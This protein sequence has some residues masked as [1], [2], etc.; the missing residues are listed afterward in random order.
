VTAWCCA[1]H[2]L[3]DVER[4]T[5]LRFE[6]APARLDT[7]SAQFVLKLRGGEGTRIV[8]Q[9]GCGSLRKE[10]WKIREYYLRLARHV[11]RHAS[12]RAATLDGSNAV[13]NELARWSV[14][15]LYTLVTDTP[16]WPYPY[17]GIPLFSTVFG[18]DGIITALLTLWAD[19]TIAKGVIGFLAAEQA[20][21]VKP[22]SDA[23][24]GKILHE[25]REGELGAARRG[26][27]RPLLRQRRR[28]AALCH[29]GGRVFRADRQSRHD[30]CLVAQHH[31]GIAADR[32]LRRSRRRRVC[33]I[34][35]AKRNR[36]EQ[37][38]LEGVDV[39]NE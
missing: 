4:D 26:A 21:S 2:G 18:R 25:M 29:A 19:P 6:P 1:T 33:R 10:G 13:F 20:T 17:A 3:D 34:P 35:A 30:P 8:L 22:E 27:V 37:P 9:A 12:G 28:D 38:G 36:V 14:A 32:H 23:A 39:V 7:S 24:P 5:N 15:V 16:N 31:H 11:L